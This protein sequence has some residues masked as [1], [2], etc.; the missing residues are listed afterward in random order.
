MDLAL[1]DQRVD[2]VAEIVDR[3]PAVDGHD[4]RRRIDFQ[5]TDVHARGEGEVGRIPEGAFLQARLQLL[6]VELVG[7]VGLQGDRAEVGRL[8]GA[9]D[10]ELAV[11]ELD[12]AFRRLENVG[13]DLFRL[14][15]DLVE[16]LGNGRHAD[17]AGARA[18]GAHAHL[19]LV[20][21]AMHDR[22]IVDR[23]AETRGHELREGRL[24]PLAVRV[25]A[26][27]NLD[28]ADRIDAHFRRFPQADAG[29]ERTD[30]RRRRDAAGFDI[31][32][33]AETAQLALGGAGR[34]ACREARRVVHLLRLGERGV[35]V[36]DVIGH[37]HRRLMREL[38]HEVLAAE[39]GRIL[40]E[41]AR[42]DLDQAFD[43]I[44]RF[45]TAGAAIGVDRG[46][47]GVDRLHLGVDRRDVVLARQQGR[48]QVGRHRRREGR[49]IRAHVGLGRDAQR[50]DLA[51]LVH[52]HFGVGDVI[53]A[54]RVRQ[55][56]FGA[57][58]RPL[59]GTIHLARRP[60]ADRL[61]G[62]DEDLRAEAAADVGRDHT[63]L[64]FRREPDEGREHETRD[65]RVLARRV[66]G[67]RIRA[68]VV[69][70]DRRARLHR[71]RDQTIV[72]DV[73]LGDVLG[74]GE[75][76]IRARLV[77]ELPVVELVVGRL[78]MDCR[79]AG[80]AGGSHV[81]DRGQ[82]LVV[83]VDHLGRVARLGE[84]IGDDDGDVIADIAHLALRE[85]GV[86]AGA[87]RRAVLVEDRPAADQAADLV[88]RDVVAGEDRDDARRR[89]G[90][91][92][93]DRLD[94]R[95]RMRRTQKIGVG[96]ART[97]DVVDVAALARDEAE[98]FLSAHGGADALIGHDASSRMSL[99]P[100]LPSVRPWRLRRR[101]S[102]SQ[103][104]GSRCSG[105]YCLPARDGWWPRRGPR[106]CG[107]RCRRP[108]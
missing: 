78:V 4:A 74:L 15:L 54:M 6:S 37:D 80:L 79:R 72:D 21:V 62:V 28:R 86:G 48:V 18:V 32:G 107:S 69:F 81:R 77:A 5:L 34:L 46:G 9:L 16:R 104:C 53:A 41:F 13:G 93:V 2:D 49:E 85:R 3:G 55:E 92:K 90:V 27:Q 50:G 44:G 39:V 76:R 68:H 66:E 58:G 96:L 97:I 17:S 12:V 38:R 88:G 59:H 52:R 35:V 91:L 87:H 89:R 40:A 42:G 108:T 26:R 99:I 102:P 82:N 94:L 7:D 29:A 11:L 100:R 22:D 95:V 30:R 61:F 63:E 19:H 43:D 45:G 33:V 67:E 103:C 71:V 31:G 105:R 64:V 60:D 1:D 73:E 84:R 106:P 57:I 83:D 25:R 70:A 14:G 98:I 51:V 101:R 10:G 23:N 75:G 47:I 20:G 8:V 24:V 56:G 36:A 65:M